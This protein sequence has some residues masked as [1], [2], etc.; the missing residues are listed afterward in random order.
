M[1]D[2]PHPDQL[3]TRAEIAAQLGISKPGLVNRI[4]RYT[5]PFPSPRGTRRNKPSG[6][7]RKD[8]EVFSWAEVEAW[9]TSRRDGRGGAMAQEERAAIV[10]QYLDGC[11]TLVEI[12]R[13]VGRSKNSVRRVLHAAGVYSPCSCETCRSRFAAAGQRLHAGRNRHD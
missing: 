12:A 4:N 2:T 8:L 7:G 5:V 3:M 6:T 11:H 10:Q 9:A 1:A 13:R